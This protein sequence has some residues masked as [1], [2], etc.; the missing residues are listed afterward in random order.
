MLT[1]DMEEEAW[2]CQEKDDKA[3][4][5]MDALAAKSRKKRG[6]DAE[7]PAEEKETVAEE[8][9]AEEGGGKRRRKALIDDDEEDE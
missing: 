2:R 5:A 9:A 8:E 6:L 1:R 7:T 3:K 4:K